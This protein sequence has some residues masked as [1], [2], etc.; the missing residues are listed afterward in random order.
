MGGPFLIVFADH[1]LRLNPALSNK[2]FKYLYIPQWRQ[3]TY[4]QADV[5]V[6]KYQARTTACKIEI[7]SS[8]QSQPV[9]LFWMILLARNTGARLQ[10]SRAGFSCL[11]KYFNQQFSIYYKLQ[12]KSTL[13]LMDLLHR[14]YYTFNT[15][16]F[17]STVV[18]CIGCDPTDLRRFLSQLMLAII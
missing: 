8:I 16:D 6:M 4:Y 7:N 9:A 15:A 2:A 13:I 1:F 18:G 3:Y 10:V 11:C 5:I 14:A 17:D 12:T